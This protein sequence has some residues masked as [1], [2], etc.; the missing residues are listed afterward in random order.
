MNIGPYFGARRGPG[1][2]LFCQTITTD[3]QGTYARVV[4]GDWKTHFD[5]LGHGLGAAGGY[6]IVHTDPLPPAA[7]ADYRLALGH[8]QAVYQENNP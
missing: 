5:A 2:W 6:T 4:N 1:D 7:L 3:G 8:M